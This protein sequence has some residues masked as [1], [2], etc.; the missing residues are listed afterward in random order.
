MKTKSYIF[1]LL[2]Y[3][4]PFSTVLAQ[5]S[6]HAE[7]VPH[8]PNLLGKNICIGLDTGMLRPDW[9]TPNV[10]SS[11]VF[12]SQAST[13]RIIFDGSDELD[14][15]ELLANKDMCNGYSVNEP[16]WNANHR[17]KFC[18]KSW[19][20]E[21]FVLISMEIKSAS[22]SDSNNIASSLYSIGSCKIG[23]A[24]ADKRVGYFYGESL[25]VDSLPM[26]APLK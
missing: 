22:N 20:Q 12:G 17:A 16:R 8:Q 19:D 2:I 7:N 25:K 26:L 18:L 9:K 3:L 24:A 14:I 4:S 23:D 5:G 15:S 10:I 13:H 21:K 11:S 6:F 1:G